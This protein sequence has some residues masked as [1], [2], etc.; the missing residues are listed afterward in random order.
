MNRKLK[1]ILAIAL[2][3][4]MSLG[5]LAAAVEGSA[6]FEGESDPTGAE[7]GR[8]GSVCAC[9][10]TDEEKAAA[11]FAHQK[12]C[13]LFFPQ[14]YTGLM[15]AASGEAVEALVAGLTETDA[16]DFR[17]SL[18]ES[19]RAALAAHI[20]EIAPGGLSETPQA[21]GLSAAA[22]ISAVT[23]QSSGGEIQLSAAPRAAEPATGSES[24]VTK[25]TAAVNADGSYTVS[26]EAYASDALD[27]RLTAGAV[28]KDVVSPYFEI[29]E[30][31]S[32]SL[33]TAA[34]NADGTYAEKTAVTA[35]AGISAGISGSTVSATGFDY[36]AA[37]LSATA[38]GDGSFGAKLIVEY[39][40]K[41]AAGFWGGNKVPAAAANSGLYTAEDV[42]IENFEQHR[43][44]AP[45]SVP[46]ITATDRNIYLL[47]TAPTAAELCD[48]VLPTGGD[49]WMT[50]Y[51]NVT[52]PTADKTAGNTADTGN[53]T[54]TVTASS[55]Q[56]GAGAD[57]AAAQPVSKTATANVRVFKPTVT[58]R[59][60]EIYLGES[61]DYAANAAGTVWKHG[62]TADTAAVMT[63][64]AP[65]LA[66]EYT[67]AA[68]AFTTDTDV[69]VKTLI[70]STDVTSHTAFAN[71]GHAASDH[72]FTVT[73]A[74][75]TLTITGP[76]AAGENQGFIYSVA[77]PGGLNFTVSVNDNGTAV[78]SGLPVGSYTV[79]EKGW[80]WRHAASSVTLELTAQAPN[81]APAL[82]CTPSKTCLFSGSAYSHS[83]PAA[84]GN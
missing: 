4:I 2:C 49:L 6:D 67:P 31:T 80:S 40:I 61:A 1:K 62:E 57:G 60:S 39:T 69:A 82:T 9:A 65:A 19:E 38:K 30:G 7:T 68:A 11:D 37:C 18:T 27:A 33:Y 5:F 20:S 48:F 14:L 32:V 66:F 25:K 26:I 41:A 22:F 21:G 52:G 23:G 15:A 81:G 72:Q 36:S 34:Y 28:L 43:V 12:G 13:P 76:G 42:L 59:D 84:A 77:G 75:C 45:I 64:S 63:G 3:L 70:G 51:V 35:E 29:P 50:A 10:G 53:I 47:N 54:L 74:T 44:N 58:F 16:A 17:A 78:I 71:A 56:S 46:D 83:A 8:E 73:V 55:K 79:S 24:L